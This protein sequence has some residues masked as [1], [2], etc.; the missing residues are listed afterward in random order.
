MNSNALTKK[1]NL[2]YKTT[3]HHINLLLEN[4][5]IVKTGDKYGQVF[6]ISLQ[7]KDN[8]SLFK[9]LFEKKILKEERK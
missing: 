8:W 2:D 1:V 3:Q 4:Q 7:L 5:L 6:F 9:K